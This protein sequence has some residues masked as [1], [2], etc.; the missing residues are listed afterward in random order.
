MRLQRDRLYCTDPRGFAGFAGLFVALRKKS[1]IKTFKILV[2]N[3][4]L[5]AER[6][7]RSRLPVATW[8]I[9]FDS[10]T[11]VQTLNRARTNQ[12]YKVTVVLRKH[13]IRYRFSLVISIIFTEAR[14]STLFACR[15]HR[16]TWYVGRYAL[17]ISMRCECRDKD[18]GRG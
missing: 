6:S 13:G 15:M 11:I 9:I 10:P 16:E 5:I 17:N 18:P 8:C 12:T 3:V 7:I 14:R 1:F 2:R 4:C